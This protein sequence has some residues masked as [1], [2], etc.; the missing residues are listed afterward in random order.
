MT[1]YLLNIPD[2]NSWENDI[3]SVTLEK[4]TAH[5]NK[6]RDDLDNLELPIERQQSLQIILESLG[7]FIGSYRT[8]A[9]IKYCFIHL[10]RMW[11]DH[12]MGPNKWFDVEKRVSKEDS[13]SM[14]NFKEGPKQKMLRCN[15]S[16]TL[17]LHTIS[18]I[19][20]W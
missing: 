8:A 16:S 17:R 7:K 9:P 14:F 18:M 4:C 11:R 3:V 1:I 5:N 15:I 20:S 2:A 10:M 6:L 12:F 13:I 19:D